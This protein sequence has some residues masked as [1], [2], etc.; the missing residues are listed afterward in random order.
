MFYYLINICCTSKNLLISPLPIILAKWKYYVFKR[1]KRTFPSTKYMIANNACKLYIIFFII[2][3]FVADFDTLA[4]KINRKAW[5][6]IIITKQK[7]TT[8]LIFLDMLCIYDCK[9]EKWSYF[10]IIE[11]FV[12]I[13]IYS[14]VNTI[15]LNKL[16]W[17][18]RLPLI[19][20]GE[21]S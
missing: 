20:K 10:L 19:I 4:L 21:G 2:Y 5:K 3:K 18:I 14:T 1:F 7:L 16:P 17:S 9:S 6:I 11:Y 13:G 12:I 8:F 15:I